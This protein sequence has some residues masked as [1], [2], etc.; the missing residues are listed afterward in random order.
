MDILHEKPG[1]EEGVVSWPMVVNSYSPWGPAAENI[2]FRHVF[3]QVRHPL[4]VITSWYV[5]LW[6]MESD[7][8]RLIR[9]H[10]P[11]ISLQK[12]SLLEHCAKYWYYWNLK[13]E[14]M[15]HWRYRIE[16]FEQVIPEMSKRLNYSF[17]AEVYSN[18]P[19]N[20]NSWSDTSKRLTWAELKQAISEDL[21][22]KIEKMALR[23]GYSIKDIQNS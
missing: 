13:A 7:E 9:Q 11:E 22:I 3:H 2:K 4:G 1:G 8:W 19:K 23:Y 16:D 12:D 20:L 14:R 21:Y 17:H 15:A 6:N 18:L 5:N 10:V